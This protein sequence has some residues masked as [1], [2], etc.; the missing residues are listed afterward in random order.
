MAS[1]ASMNGYGIYIVLLQCMVDLCSWPMIC[2]CIYNIY[3]IYRFATKLL[4]NN[5]WITIMSM[6]STANLQCL[7]GFPEFA[8]VAAP[9]SISKLDRLLKC[10][11]SD[12]WH[13]STCKHCHSCESYTVCWNTSRYPQILE[14]RLQNPMSDF[15][16]IVCFLFYSVISKPINLRGHSYYLYQV[17]ALVEDPTR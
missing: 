1:M 13:L 9:P 14:P 8:D 2:W 5:Y 7:Q 15:G 16:P 6:V 11:R 17:D 12:V 10:W 3:H 4:P